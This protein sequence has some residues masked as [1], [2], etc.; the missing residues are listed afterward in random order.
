VAVTALRGLA[1]RGATSDGSGAFRIGNL[2]AGTIGMLASKEGFSMVAPAPG[3][4]V[5]LQDGERRQEVVLRM[6]PAS[7]ITGRVLDE[8]GEPV[9]RAYVWL[10][11]MGVNA[12]GAIGLVQ[13]SLG[14]SDDLGRYRLPRVAPGAYV[15]LTV[16]ELEHEDETYL[17]YPGVV[18]L[19]MAHMLE[20]PEGRDVT[21]IDFRLNRDLGHQLTGTVIQ[22]TPGSF[23][24]LRAELTGTDADGTPIRRRSVNLSRSGAF[25]FLNVA[26]GRYTVSVLPPP[27]QSALPVVIDGSVVRRPPTSVESGG[28]QIQVGETQPDP[29]VIRTAPA[30]PAPA[31]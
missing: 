12:D 6:V 10:L 23:A 16:G 21:G 30:T 11:R 17:Y 13:V 27:S 18:S 28:V 31:R 25:Q 4:S 8:F 15:L 14:R 3:V 5:S 19:R 26:P 9:E 20:V 1:W 2:D 24:G 22:S 29:L 7:Q